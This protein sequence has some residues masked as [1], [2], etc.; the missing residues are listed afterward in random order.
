MAH[1][2][3]AMEKNAMEG[4]FIKRDLGRSREKRINSSGLAAEKPLLFLSLKEHV[5]EICRE[6][7]IN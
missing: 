2:S 1:S 6:L 4:L 7:Q 5:E 3:R